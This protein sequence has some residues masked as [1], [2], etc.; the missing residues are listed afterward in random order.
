MSSA[1]NGVKKQSQVFVIVFLKVSSNIHG[2]GGNNNFMSKPRRLRKVKGR[3]KKPF[4]VTTS[5][6]SIFGI[7]MSSKCLNDFGILIHCK[8]ECSELI[9]K[10][11]IY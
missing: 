7:F 2:C 3:T 5:E 11:L 1:G 9:P 8:P 10:R 4:K 6:T